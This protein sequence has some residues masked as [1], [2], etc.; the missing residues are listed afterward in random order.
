MLQRKNAYGINLLYLGNM[1]YAS[2]F[3]KICEILL[4]KILWELCRNYAGVNY[5]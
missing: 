1:E 3:K 5:T 2:V 4:D